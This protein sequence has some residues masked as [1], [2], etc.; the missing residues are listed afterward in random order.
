MEDRDNQLP[1]LLCAKNNPDLGVLTKVS[2]QRSSEFSEKL[3]LSASAAGDA[4]HAQ[5]LLLQ[6]ANVGSRDHGGRTALHLA[7]RG[8]ARGAEEVVKLLLA[9]R[10]IANAMDHVAMTPMDMAVLVQNWGIKKLLE[11]NGVELQPI[12]KRK[13]QESSWLLK[14]SELQLQREIGSTLKSVVHLADWHGTTVVVKCIKM[15]QRVIMNKM[16]RS[17]SFDLSLARELHELDDVPLKK[18]DCS[19]EEAEIEHMCSSGVPA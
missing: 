18:E 8:T 6:K 17:K 4:A 7:S 3:L 10:A 5:R 11:Q 13:A 16:K 12:L 15:K 2:E 14:A 9:Q 1:M 19:P